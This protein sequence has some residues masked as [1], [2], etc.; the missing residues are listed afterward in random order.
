MWSE[1]SDMKDCAILKLVLPITLSISR[2][3]KSD[4]F[5]NDIK[6]VFGTNLYTNLGSRN[7][8]LL[9]NHQI[10]IR[11]FKMSYRNSSEIQI[12]YNVFLAQ[13]YFNSLSKEFIC[14]QNGD[15]WLLNNLPLIFSTNNFFSLPLFFGNWKIQSQQ[16]QPLVVLK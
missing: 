4:Y 12:F 9:E 16:R 8:S 3:M 14:S 15:C 10:M 7:E 6:A 1:R 2:C 5:Q 11:K 13:A